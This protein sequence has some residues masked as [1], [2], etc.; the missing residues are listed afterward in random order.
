MKIEFICSQPLFLAL[1]RWITKK[2]KVLKNLLGET[3]TEDI[4]EKKTETKETDTP[5][6]T[7]TT[8]VTTL[9]WKPTA[10]I[11]LVVDQTAYPK[12]QLTND[13]IEL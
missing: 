13:V 4:E 9:F 6:N 7:N 8:Y 12:N 2:K 11:N 10:T 3:T 1:S 5:A